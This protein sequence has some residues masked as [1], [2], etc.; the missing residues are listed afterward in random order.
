MKFSLFYLTTYYA[1]VHG[2]ERALYEQI[3]AEIDEGERIG[4]HGTWLAEHH[5]FD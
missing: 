3:L 5:F 2:S 4:M 1:E